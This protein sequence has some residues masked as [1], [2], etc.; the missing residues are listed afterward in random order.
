MEILYVTAN[1]Y[2]HDKG[3]FTLDERKRWLLNG[4]SPVDPVI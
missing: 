2:D 3:L 1:L 4:P